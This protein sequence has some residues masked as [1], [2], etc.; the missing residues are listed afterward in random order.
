MRYT[1]QPGIFCPSLLRHVGVAPLWVVHV[2]Y[3]VWIAV[4]LVLVLAASRLAYILA[5]RARAELT[6]SVKPACAEAS[7]ARIPALPR[8]AVKASG[9][10]VRTSAKLLQLRAC[11]QEE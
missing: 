6:G 11:L 8:V 9:R 7:P 1:S 5:R 4:G 2:L 10:D 3:A